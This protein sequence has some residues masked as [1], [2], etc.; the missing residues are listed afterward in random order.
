MS[1]ELSGRTCWEDG[2]GECSR[3]AGPVEE[4]FE[5]GGS[6]DVLAVRLLK[7]VVG[8]WTEVV[9]GASDDDCCEVGV[10]RRELVEVGEDD[11]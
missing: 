11:V 8:A 7:L 10:T 2:V 3:E 1:C 6:D 9:D 5:C 4:L